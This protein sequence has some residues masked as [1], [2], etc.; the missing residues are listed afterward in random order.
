MFLLT[1]VSL[2]EKQL[3]ERGDLIIQVFA[4]INNPRSPVDNKKSGMHSS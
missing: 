3:K 2:S 4:G 1:A